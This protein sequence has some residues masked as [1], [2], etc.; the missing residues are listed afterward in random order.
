MSSRSR[1]L[2]SPTVRL[3][4]RATSRSFTSSP[5]ERLAR[6]ARMGPTAWTVPPD[7]TACRA[8]APAL[9]ARTA[10]GAATGR[11]AATEVRAAMAETA[12]TSSC[13]FN[14]AQW[15]ARTTTSPFCGGQSSARVAPAG[16]AG[17]EVRAAEAGAVDWAARGP[18]ASNP[19]TNTSTSV[20]GGSSGMSG[21]DGADGMSGP[22]GRA[23][24]P[25]PSA[26]RWSHPRRSYEHPA[27]RDPGRST[28]DDRRGDVQAA[29]GTC[30]RSRQ[31]RGR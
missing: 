19:D 16:P 5:A 29:N 13:S 31:S 15:P 24:R 14:A 12:V 17:R 28:R 26:S 27:T 10:P 30:G 18:A 2:T 3:L 22:G 9:P 7:S 21:S 25:G 11:P 20:S 4:R 23:G 8:V 6:R 1:A